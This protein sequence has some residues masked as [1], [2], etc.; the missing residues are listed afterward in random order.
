M[1][2]CRKCVKFHPDNYYCDFMED[3]VEPEVICSDEDCPNYEERKSD[4][5]ELFESVTLDMCEVY[6]AKNH[7]YGNSFEE[8][9]K[10][11]PNAILVRLFDKYMRLETLMNGETAQV[12]ESID[13]TL[14]DLANYCVLELVARQKDKIL[15]NDR[16]LNEVIAND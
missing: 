10:R 2:D 11:F 15:E 5:L 3:Y 13:D 6:A 4:N 8:L 1:I 16:K 12:D 7:D 9:R 14:L